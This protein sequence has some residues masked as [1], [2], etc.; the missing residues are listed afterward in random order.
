MARTTLAPA[1][2]LRRWRQRRLLNQRQM[3]AQL[4]MSQQM[5]ACI[6]LGSRQPSRKAAAKIRKVTGI[7]ISAWP[8]LAERFREDV[9]A[10]SRSAMSG[11]A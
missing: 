6:E 2:R 11:K 8:T 4:E 3:A 7:P 9:T 5:V 1:D 10:P